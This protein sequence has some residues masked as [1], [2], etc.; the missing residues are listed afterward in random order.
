M[1]ESHKKKDGR[2]PNTDSPGGQENKNLDA[3][4]EQNRD[5][6]KR[7]RTQGGNEDIPFKK[8]KLNSDFPVKKKNQDFQVKKKKFNGT[9]K[10]NKKFHKQKSSSQNKRQFKTKP[11]WSKG[12]KER[13]KNKKK[14]V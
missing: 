10:S 11:G 1:I 9:V 5:K 13:N 2:L 14:K 12:F 8:K 6:K 7:K 3:E 4:S